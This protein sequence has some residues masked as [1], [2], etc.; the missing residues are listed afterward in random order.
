MKDNS[1]NIRA[2]YVYDAWGNHKVYNAS[3]VEQTSSTF[4]GNINPIRYRGYYYDTE[5]DMYYCKSRYYKPQINRWINMDDISYLD[6]KNING[7]NLYAYCYDNPIMYSDPSG[8]IALLIT[9]LISGVIAVG[10]NIFSQMV[11]EDKS[12]SEIVWSEVIISGLSGFVSGFVPGSGFLSLVG[13]SAVSAFVD[14]NLRSLIY[15]EEFSLEKVIFDAAVQIITG[16]VAMGISSG[17]D[18]LTSKITNKVFIKARNYSQYQHY[19]RGKGFDFTVD[20]VYKHMY[21][22][23]KLRDITNGLVHHTVEKH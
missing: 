14:S 8:H 11:L 4:V 17:I 13:Q 19:Y 10:A 5:S 21:R 16:T 7:L 15:G 6:K 12:F 22:H 1:N 20:E 18:K 23:V 9:A 2:K 3:G